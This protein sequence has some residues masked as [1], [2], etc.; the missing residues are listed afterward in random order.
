MPPLPL[1]QIKSMKNIAKILAAATVAFAGAP[2]MADVDGLKLNSVTSN[3][4]QNVQSNS[5]AV[6][7]APMGG[8]NAN[9][10]I[11][12]VSNSEY[13]FAPGIKCP[14]PELAFGVFGGQTNGW[15][16][17]GYNNSGNNLGGTAMVTMPFGGGDI[18]KSCR[19]LAA[20]IAR[21]RVLDT[22]LNMIKQC[23]QLAT[24][25]VTLDVD[26]F[27]QF[28]RCDGVSVQGQ[29]VVLVNSDPEP[30]F[31]PTEEVKPVI[32]ISKLD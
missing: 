13:G 9:Y 32:D 7:L 20:E 15:G 18:A 30:I 3:S 8:S 6:N 12:S 29:S 24:A 2:A 21:Q 27:P 23:A 17:T 26:K 19:T 25:N 16:N 14:T 31:T 22:E 4:A 28:D 11:N 10:Q 1:Y 5:G